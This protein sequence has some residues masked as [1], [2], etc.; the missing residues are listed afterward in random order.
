MTH[1]AVRPNDTPHRGLGSLPFAVV[2][3]LAAAPN[4][5]FLGTHLASPPLAAGACACVVAA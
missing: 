4:L 3:G 1:D 2:L 5:L